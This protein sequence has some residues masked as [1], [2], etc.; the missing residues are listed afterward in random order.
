M[1]RNPILLLPTLLTLG[2]LLCGVYATLL[3]AVHESAGLPWIAPCLILLG[4]LLDGVDGAAARRLGVA[5]EFGARL[6]SLADLVT[7]G[8]APA[9]LVVRLSEPGRLAWV[10]AAWLACAA[11]LRL[12]RFSAAPDDRRRDFQGLPCPAA[13]ALLAAAAIAV[14]Y[15]HPRLEADAYARLSAAIAAVTPATAAGLGLLLVSPVPYAH[16]VARLASH[17][18]QARLAVVAGVSGAAALF[19]GYAPLVISG[20]FIV[21]PLWL[22]AAPARRPLARPRRDA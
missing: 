17:G 9:L 19:G 3:L 20:L 2:N 10:A 7:F 4:L 8:V 13:A 11:A 18:S 12:A 16:P 1:T 5:S 22:A 6:D 15:A 14:A 21:S